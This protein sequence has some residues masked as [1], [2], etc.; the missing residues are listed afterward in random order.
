MI[1]DIGCGFLFHHKNRAKLA[2]SCPSI[3]IDINRGTCDLLAS[4]EYIPLMKG[5][6][7][8]IL[9]RNC[10]E[11]MKNPKK[12][13]RDSY[14]VAKKGARI[15]ISLPIHPNPCIDELI[16]F[17]IGFPFRTIDTILRLIRWY[18]Q[19]QFKGFGHVNR[20]KPEDITYYFN[21]TKVSKIRFKHPLSYGR[22]GKLLK[23]IIG[24]FLYM[25]IPNLYL[26][27]AKK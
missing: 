1:L 13:L 19:K 11:H 2:S 24:Q 12:C 27:E 3:G 16:Q 26:I 21:V 20:L 17:I 10:L 4:G 18:K 25:P 22:K 7:D 23:K 14:R 5:I 6:A 9:L 8:I 15:S